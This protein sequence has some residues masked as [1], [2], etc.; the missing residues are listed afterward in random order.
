MCSDMR[1]GAL[2]G[3]IKGNKNDN[4]KNRFK[5]PPFIIEMVPMILHLVANPDSAL[6]N[7]L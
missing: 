5:M 2:L 1:F 4:N 7:S 6:G 3:K